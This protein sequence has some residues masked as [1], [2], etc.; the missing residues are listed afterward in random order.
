MSPEN[1]AAYPQHGNQK[2]GCGFPIA[3]IMATFSLLTGALR[4][5]CIGDW[6]THEVTLA[7][8][9]YPTL[10][11]DTVVLGDAIFGS[12][13]DFWLLLQYGLDGLFQKQGARKTD[14]RTG[15]HLGKNECAG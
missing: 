12:Y 4:K 10:A 1:Q 8:E 3:R 15:Q 2:E 7:R 14:F 9:I 13:A 6:K 11:P 5:L